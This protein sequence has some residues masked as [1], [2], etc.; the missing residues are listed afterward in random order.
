MCLVLQAAERLFNFALCLCA[1]ACGQA[2][3]P[4]SCLPEED[5]K[6]LGSGDVFLEY[7]VQYQYYIV[8]YCQYSFN[9]VLSYCI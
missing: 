4:P 7:I 2:A 1:W 8:Q 3:S 6:I 9:I 5:A